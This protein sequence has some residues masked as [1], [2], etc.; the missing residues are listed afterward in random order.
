MTPISGIRWKCIRCPDYDLCSACESKGVHKETGHCF[1]KIEQPRDRPLCG[2]FRRHRW[3]HMRPGGWR[4]CGRRQNGC[5]FGAPDVAIYIARFVKDVTVPD[6][7]QLAPSTPFL[8]I[9]KMRNDGEKPWPANT[10]LAFIGG[11]KFSAA[12][13]VVLSE[14]VSPGVSIDIAVDMVAPSAPGKYVSY[15]RL[16]TPDGNRFG[17]RIWVDV[18]VA[19]D[20]VKPVNTQEEAKENTETQD[21]LE[22]SVDCLLQLDKEEFKEEDEVEDLGDYVKIEDAKD[23]EPNIPSVQQPAPIQEPP[24]PVDIHA[25]ALK[26]LAD[27]GFIDQQLNRALLY[28]NGNDIMR[29]IQDLLKGHY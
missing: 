27:M 7:T 19:A 20:E 16:V 5:G 26:I 14:S 12:E 10:R 15:Y 17:H 21:D 18:L 2:P 23:V 3:G 11:D 13:S 24:K 1:V 6:G 28:R 4:G 25:D 9:W 8:K 22:S 29:T